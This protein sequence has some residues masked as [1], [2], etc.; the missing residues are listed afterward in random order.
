MV[1]Q[2]LLQDDVQPALPM[3]VRSEPGSALLE[4][5]AVFLIPRPL[6]RCVTWPT[7]IVTVKSMSV[8]GMPAAHVV[9][10]LGKTAMAS[11]TI[12]MESSTKMQPVEWFGLL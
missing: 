11:M 1:A 6:K 2:Q 4:I 8:F 10:P 12:V 5:R 3:H 9:D 7:M